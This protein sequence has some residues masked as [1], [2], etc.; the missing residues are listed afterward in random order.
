MATDK[1]QVD[2]A[3][4]VEDAKGP[5]C[6]CGQRGAHYCTGKPNG[7]QSQWGGVLPA[8]YSDESKVATRVTGSMTA[9]YKAA[10]CA[11]SHNYMAH[12]WNAL[13][14]IGGPPSYTCER[15]RAFCVIVPDKPPIITT[16][17]DMERNIQA[18]DQRM[19]K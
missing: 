2:I 19:D 4:K 6:E 3:Q 17:A 1:S 5:A 8:T 14:L 18:A 15:C 7:Q 10:T 13:R 9:H 12:Y 11:N 16:L